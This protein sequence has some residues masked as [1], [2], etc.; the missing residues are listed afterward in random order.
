M[1]VEVNSV[2]GI[3]LDSIILR[4]PSCLSCSSDSTSGG[5]I[6]MTLTPASRS[7]CLSLER[8]S[9]RVRPTERRTHEMV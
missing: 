1:T 9:Q 8:A 5:A 2:S 3:H 7:T 6:S 4:V